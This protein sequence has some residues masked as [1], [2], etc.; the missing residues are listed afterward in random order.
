MVK[1]EVRR[2]EARRGEARR[3]EVVAVS[4][5]T[6]PVVSHLLITAF[7]CLFVCFYPG[8]HL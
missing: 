2:S 5:W 7:V 4:R 6:V 1:C 3:G 8:W